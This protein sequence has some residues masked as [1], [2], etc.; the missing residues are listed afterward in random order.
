MRLLYKP[1]EKDKV[2]YA[3][4]LLFSFI[5]IPIIVGFLQVFV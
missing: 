3:A 5:W 4:L 2:I 1:T